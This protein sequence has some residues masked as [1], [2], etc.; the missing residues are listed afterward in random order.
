MYRSASYNPFNESIFLRTWSE[1]GERIDTE[2]PFRPFLFL[3]KEGATDAVSIFKTSLIKKQFKIN[4]EKELSNFDFWVFIDELFL[5]F[6]K[7][8]CGWQAYSLDFL[9]SWKL[10]LFARI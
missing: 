6:N 8:F 2:I 10:A 9:L 7:R 4:Y 3:E 5:F 1:D